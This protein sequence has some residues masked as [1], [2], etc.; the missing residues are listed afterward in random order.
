[1][2]LSHS[3]T[4][5]GEPLVLI[6]GIGMQWQAFNGL[7]GP[8]SREREVIAVD[9]PG[10]GASPTLPIGTPPHPKALARAVAA[11]LDSQGIERPVLGGLSLGGWVALELAKLGR[12][13]ALVLISPAGFASPAQ[14]LRSRVQLVATRALARRVPRLIERGLRTRAGAS[15]LLSGTIGHPER[16]PYEDAV[17][18]N[19]TVAAAPGFDGTLHQITRDRFSGGD[20]VGVPVTVM[21]GTHDRLLSHRQARSA[22]KQLP[23]AR[24]VLLQGAGHLPMW[25]EPDALVRELL[26]A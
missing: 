2:E 19:R 3:R 10:F 26:A 18:L 21:W 16:V 22:L 15:L 9:L 23:R 4:G 5:S 6:H 1:V 20:R 24:H 7:I 12:A 13:R 11:F 14:Q 17:A 8:L 25:D